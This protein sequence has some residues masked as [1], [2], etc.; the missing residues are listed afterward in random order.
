[1]KIQDS[2][3]IGSLAML[4]NVAAHAAPIYL[5]SGPQANVSLST[6][7]SGGWTQCYSATMATFIGN[8]GGSVLSQCSG[9]YLMMAGRET[10]S[11]SF[12]ALAAALY[13]D[14]I[15]DTGNTSVT[16]LANGSNWWYSD[17]WSWGFTQA[18]DAVTNNECDTSNSPLSMCLH[19][20]S[21][22]GGY[23]INNITD[24]NNSNAYEKVFFVA[25][26]NPNAVVEPATLALLG[27]GLSGLAAM[28]SRKKR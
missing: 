20:V 14:T 19:T 13:A 11:Q 26:A 12:L 2:L 8:A 4:V 1:M 21:G 27:I 17:N 22:A 15:V 5:P 6:I 25:N 10:G 7:T 23:R 16:H 9:D 18:N 3:V 28:R 24:L